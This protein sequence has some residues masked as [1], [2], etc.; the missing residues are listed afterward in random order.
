MRTLV[1]VLALALPSP[2][3][4]W[5]QDSV[6]D[7]FAAGMDFYWANEMD[8]AVVYLGVAAGDTATD[9]TRWAWLAEAQRRA[10]RSA[11]AA[12]TARA[13]LVLATVSGQCNAFAHTVLADALNPQYGDW[14]G[15]DADLAWK[16][17][18]AAVEC[19][20]DDGNAWLE[21]VF[22]AVM[23]GNDELERRALGK[24]VETGF[25][26]EA[27]LAH[28]R[29]VL[30]G[31]PDS[32]V[33]ITNGDLDTYPALALQVSEGVRTDVAVINVSLLDVARY[34]EAMA[35]RHGLPAVQMDPGAGQQG[36]WAPAI[37]SALTRASLAGD[38]ARPVAFAA[39]IDPTLL[40]ELPATARFAGTHWLAGPGGTA[41]I[42][43][44]ATRRAMEA[45]DA[46]ALA[47]PAV[48]A[49]DRSPVRRRS[50]AL[51]L[52]P[53]LAAL[54]YGCALTAADREREA[55]RTVHW[56]RQ[57]VHDVGAGERYGEAID[58]L[59]AR[60]FQLG[61]WPCGSDRTP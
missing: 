21:T 33:L 54:R 56:I 14:D 18:L 47:G 60:G 53:V 35:T 44:A 43:T 20:P 39:T 52:Y 19:D 10:G 28:N 9:P 49:A 32:A 40:A 3:R 38:L 57:F 23:R 37:V 17:A 5:T 22:G 6:P 12:A 45:A 13:A 8:S 61:E 50:T 42:D 26:T 7:P 11:D 25:L 55:A 41:P 30:E 1:L 2:V 16:H 36:R 51:E 29:W 48:S 58:A 46:S 24:L 59:A 15:A 31:V 4:G 34:A 27:A